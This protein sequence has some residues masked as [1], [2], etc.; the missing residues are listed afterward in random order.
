MTFLWP[1][2]LWLLGLVPLMVLAYILMLKR[3]RKMV[4]RYASLSIV[5]DAMGKGPGFRR[6]VPP[7]LFLLAM[8]TMLVAL[9]RPA[10]YVTLPSQHGTVILAMDVSGSMRATDVEPSRFVAAQEAAKSFVAKQ[11]RYVRIGVVSFAGTAALVQPP[12]DNQEDLDNAIDRFSGQFGTATGSGILV[13]L[14]AI[15]KDIDFSS[16]YPGA[17]DV[18]QPPGG[19]GFGSG[20]FDSGFGRG[21]SLDDDR[22]QR[23]KDK[24]AP[25]EPGSYKSAVIILL[26]DG[27][28]NTGPDPIEMA[29]LA[30]DRGVR[31]FTV[32]VGTQEGAVL[33]FGQRAM[34]VQ[35]DEDSLK[36]IA[37][38]TRGKYYRA[39]SAN[40]LTDIY[41][42][43]ST[44]LV[45][46]REKTEITAF[47]TGAAALLALI[48]AFLSFWWFNR[49]A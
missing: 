13:S 30:A 10:A 22:G 36:R 9:A 44:Q 18:P 35:L 15:F 6:H 8:T 27:E 29:R 45:M 14:M 20:R 5:K 17:W 21:R 31:V 2:M 42:T 28:A 32:G 41:K 23:T 12:T 48:A 7:L 43:L 46:E 4:L 34:R 38:I 33:R 11:S 24:P 16:A 37:D 19:R 39:Q 40:D 3:K 47:F 49:L 26:T 1:E 25:V